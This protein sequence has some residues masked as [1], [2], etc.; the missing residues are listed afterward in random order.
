MTIKGSM[1]TKEPA[2][3]VLLCRKLPTCTNGPFCTN[4]RERR[5]CV[6]CDK[7]GL[8]NY[9][10]EKIGL[11]C[12]THKNPGMVNVVS[13]K[14]FYPGC[15]KF[16]VFNFLGEKTRKYCV[17]HKEPGMININNADKKRRAQKRALKN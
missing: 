12:A 16:P 5:R 14:C 17:K 7:K 10:N 9:F 2:K 11:Y 6:D 1:A 3:L 8:F 13:K 4:H 15:V